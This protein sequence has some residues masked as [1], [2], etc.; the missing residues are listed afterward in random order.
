M[1]NMPNAPLVY[2]LGV[3][4]FPRVPQVERFVDGF[5]DLVRETYPVFDEIP[6]QVNNMMLDS[7]GQVIDVQHSEVRMLQFAT[8]DRGWAFLLT[9]EFLGLHTI[10]YVDN[11]DFIERLKT[12]VQALLEVPKMGVGWIQAIG[13]RY[14]DLVVPRQGER[15]HQ[16]LSPWVIPPDAPGMTFLEGAYVASYKTPGGILRFQS[17]RNPPTTLP[18]DLDTPMIQRNNWKSGRPDGEFV[19]MDMDHGC[20]FDPAVAMDVDMIGTKLSELRGIS[21]ALF[22]QTGT[23][24]AINIWKGEA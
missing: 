24:Y 20:R 4:R 1:T 2:T 7:K 5:H 22:Q 21:K 9:E 17:L 10:R 18:P 11:R 16:Y 23:D 12:G 19:L 8:H 6:V 3:V 15:L 13:L 14:I